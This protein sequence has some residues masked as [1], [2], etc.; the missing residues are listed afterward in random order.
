VGRHEGL[1]GVDDRRVITGER[2]AGFVQGGMLCRSYPVPITC[3]P[4]LG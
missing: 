2:V 3:S 4:I 1:D